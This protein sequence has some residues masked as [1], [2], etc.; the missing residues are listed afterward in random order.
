MRI[1][2][3]PHVLLRTVWHIAG[4][5]G[6]RNTDR[7]A[8]CGWSPAWW[9]SSAVMAHWIRGRQCA[10][11][12]STQS[13]LSTGCS[14]A[15]CGFRPARCY[16]RCSRTLVR[17]VHGT[18]SLLLPPRHVPRDVVG[19]QMARP[20][21]SSPMLAPAGGKADTAECRAAGCCPAAYGTYTL[22]YLRR[23]QLSTAQYTE[24]SCTQ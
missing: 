18:S 4:G 20:T 22:R 16:H 14:A 23:Y 21:L 17:A 9:L 5:T 19:S 10:P 13:T 1:P 2:K 11:S 24:Y 7:S 3:H 12:Q 6:R 8:M 15:R